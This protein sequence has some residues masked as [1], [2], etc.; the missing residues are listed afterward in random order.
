MRRHWES[1][2]NLMPGYYVRCHCCG[3]LHPAKELCNQHIDTLKN[4]QSAHFLRAVTK[5]KTEGGQ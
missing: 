5:V 4:L 1:Q 3:E 2:L